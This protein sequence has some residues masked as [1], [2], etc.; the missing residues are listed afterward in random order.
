MNGKF[1][2]LIDIPWLLKWVEKKKTIKR[3]CSYRNFIRRTNK[4]GFTRLISKNLCWPPPNATNGGWHKLVEINH[5]N[6]D[7]LCCGWVVLFHWFGKFQSN[8]FREA[9]LLD[10]HSFCV[11]FFIS[12]FSV[13]LY[14]LVCCPKCSAITDKIDFVLALH[15]HN[16]LHYSI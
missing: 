6:Y 1:C 4:C 16:V 7:T 5:V 9:P 8:R 14:T 2:I 11:C 15:N 12:N 13:C 10:F 3:K